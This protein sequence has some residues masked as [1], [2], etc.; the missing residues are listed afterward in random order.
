VPI[1]IPTIET[2]EPQ[3]SRWAALP[4]EASPSITGFYYFFGTFNP[5]FFTFLPFHFIFNTRFTLNTTPVTDHWGIL[6]L[7]SHHHFHIPRRVLQATSILAH[8]KALLARFVLAF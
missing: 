2:A 8:L 5:P 7:A 6:A 1:P 3:L 4:S